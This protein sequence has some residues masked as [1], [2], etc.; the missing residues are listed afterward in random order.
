MG[1]SCCSEN[2]AQTGS[3]IFKIL[4]VIKESELSSWKK[5]KSGSFDDFSNDA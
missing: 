3:K 5:L 1:E 2:F 4:D